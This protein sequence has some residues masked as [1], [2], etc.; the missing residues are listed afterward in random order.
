MSIPFDG[1]K[2]S[3]KPHSR[4]KKC[5]CGCHS[6][7]SK[8]QRKIPYWFKYSGE[9]FYLNE[10]KGH[11]LTKWKRAIKKINHWKKKENKRKIHKLKQ[12]IKD[13]M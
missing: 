2:P 7:F 4:K 9:D 8:K 1:K 5:C 11:H 6:T 3:M 12:R 10:L 13:E